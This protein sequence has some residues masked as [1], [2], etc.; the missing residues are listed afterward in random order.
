VSTVP[1]AAVDP[2]RRSDAPPALLELRGVGKHFAGADRPALDGADLTVHEGDFIAIV[3]PSG[4]GKSTLLNVLGLLDRPDAGAYLVDGKDTTAM[5]E[6]ERDRLRSRVFG[7]VFQSSHV[8]GDEAVST[9]AA[10]GLRIQRVPWDE[11]DVR[12]GEALDLLGLGHRLG[13]RAKLLSGG[14]RQRLAIARAVATRPRV[15]LADEPTGNLD[16]ANSRIVIEH[17]RELHARGTTVL[18]ITHDPA[19]AAQADRHVRIEDGVLTESRSAPTPSA[20]AGPGS[21]GVAAKEARPPSPPASGHRASALLDDA[22]DALSSL[23]S[24]FLRTVLLMAAFAVGIGGLVASVGLSQ[25]ATAQVSA[26]L[27]A[28]ALDE[29]V[30]NLPADDGLLDPDDDRL[31]R[32]STDLAALPHVQAAGHLAEISPAD[33]R[34]TRSAPDE[35][36]PA[37]ALTLASASASYAAAADLRFPA[38]SEAVLESAAERAAWVTPDA[39]RAL[40]LPAPDS[41]VLSPGY[42]IWVEGQSVPVL[43]LVRVSERTPQLGAAVFVTRPVMAGARQPSLTLTVRTETGFPYPVSQAAPLVIDPAN[44]GRVTTRTVADLRNLRAGVSDDLGAFVGVL[45]AVLLA[46][47]V[48]SASTAMY[49]SVQSR[50]AEIALRRAI[51]S[52]RGLIARLF[53]LEGAL[54]GLAGGA[55][56]AAAGTAAVLA[57]AHARGWAAVLPTTAAPLSLALGL[58]AGVVSALYPAWVASRQRPADALRG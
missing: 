39:A 35:P 11:R 53:L 37:A 27:T 12:A 7:F 40:H 8:L 13:T 10:L 1:H 38:G 29:V 21:R 18:L 19:I 33:A 42:R 54:I 28:A 34:I 26:R 20:A 48:I 55:V 5:G 47:A 52:G 36:E 2:G 30:V 4:S 17:L 45:S 50:T 57:V 32:W 9:N 43:G 25:T 49:L 41:G 51:G 3:G 44:P 15:I 56:G 16:S 46:L 31:T 6:A 14:E 23:S 24:R 58:T 22:V